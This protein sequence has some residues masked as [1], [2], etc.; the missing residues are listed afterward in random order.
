MWRESIFEWSHPLQMLCGKHFL[1]D[2]ILIEECSL[3]C[4]T[5]T[6]FS[7]QFKSI[8]QYARNWRGIYKNTIHGLAVWYNTAKV[9]TIQ[10]FQSVTELEVLS[11]LI[12][13]ASETTLLPAVYIAPGM[14]D[15]LIECLITELHHLPTERKILIVGDFNFDQL[16]TAK[17]EKLSRLTNTFHLIQISLNAIHIHGP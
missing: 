2:K 11:V 1:T 5:E 3:L 8:E 9:K 14:G 17:I 4:F 12:E 10:E 13:M 7:E 6:H 15:R 16:L